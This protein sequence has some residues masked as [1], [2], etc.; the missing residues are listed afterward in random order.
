MQPCS[1]AALDDTW[2]IEMKCVLPGPTATRCCFCIDKIG[3]ACRRYCALCKFITST[4][5]YYDPS[6]LLVRWLVGWLVRTLTLL[7][8]N[9]SKTAGDRNSVIMEHLYE[10]VSGISNRHVLDDVTGP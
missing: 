7:G 10:I 9:F 8:P 3:R 4:R 5:I 6:C 2:R 1:A